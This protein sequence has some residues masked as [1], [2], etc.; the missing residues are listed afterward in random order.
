MR[1]P[2]KADCPFRVV[3]VPGGYRIHARS[4]FEWLDGKEAPQTPKGDDVPGMDNVAAM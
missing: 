1:G 4:F 3:K 2:D